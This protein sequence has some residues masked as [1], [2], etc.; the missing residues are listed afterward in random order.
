M[1]YYP[2][3][4]YDRQSRQAIGAQNQGQVHGL[5]PE[6]LG[7]DAIYGAAGQAPDYDWPNPSFAILT[8]KS[9][10]ARTAMDRGQYAG[11]PILLLLGQDVLYGEPGQSPDYDYP[12]P[13]LGPRRTRDYTF[14]QSLELPV[15]Q[16]LPAG[17][18]TL[19]TDLPPRA[20]LR[21]RDYTFTASFPLELIG[22]DAVN[23]GEQ[24][25]ES[26]VRT[27]RRALSLSEPGVNTTLAL[28]AASVTP[29]V[30]ILT[31]LPPRGGARASDYTFTASL[32]LELLGQD[33]FNPGSQ[34]TGN[35]PVGRSRA[36]SLADVGSNQI[37]GLTPAAP[38][39]PVSFGPNFPNPPLPKA[40]PASLY[41]PGA[42]LIALQTTVVAALPAGT[43]SFEQNP[44][45]SARARDY[46]IAEPFPLE[47][48]G[49]DIFYGAPG[50]VP[51]YDWP[52]PRG[53]ARSREYTWLQSLPLHIYQQLPVGDST[54][55]TELPPAGAKRSRD[56]TWLQSLPLYV[57]QQLPPGD[58]TGLTEGSPRGPSR[59]RDYTFLASLSL[60]LLGQDVMYGQPGEVP[61]YDWPVPKGYRRPLTNIAPSPNN[62]VALFTTP[63]IASRD[64]SYTF[65]LASGRWS[66]GLAGSRWSFGPSRE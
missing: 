62:M 16:Q 40:R 42:N 13:S 57:Y 28:D 31:E 36:T 22:Q 49:Q 52:N 29:R 43:Q 48:R 15:F 35:P 63:P 33:A 65:S 37:L 2:G 7:Q 1:P 19:N 55:A 50:E 54:A 61:V 26:P 23:P 24:V 11:A 4:A 56:Y 59:A 45:G 32:S 34:L 60:E 5:L 6:L 64:L 44:R 41:D 66:F 39:F 27:V 51:A 21:A 9:A 18:S 30:A 47:L 38:V 3:S 14:T 46:T 10:V 25:L 20:P 8:R 53:P 58:S 12:N 17:A